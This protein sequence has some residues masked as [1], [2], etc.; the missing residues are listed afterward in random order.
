MPLDIIKGKN[1]VHYDELEEVKVPTRWGDVD[2]VLYHEGGPFTGTAWSTIND[3]HTECTTY[4]GMRHGAYITADT[5]GRVLFEGYYQF[6]QMVGIHN[7]YYLSGAISSVTV[8]GVEENKVS[9]RQYN[10][11]GVLVREVKDRPWSISQ[12]NDDG[13]LFF[14]TNHSGLR[15]FNRTGFCV[16]FQDKVIRNVAVPDDNELYLCACELLDDI[17]NGFNQCNVV[18]DWL[19]SELECDV[20]RAQELHLLLLNHSNLE[21]VKQILHFRVQKYVVADLIRLMSQNIRATVSGFQRRNGLGPLTLSEYASQ[22]LDR[23]ANEIEGEGKAEIVSAVKKFEERLAKIDCRR[24]IHNKKKQA[25]KKKW[26][27]IE[28][29]LKKSDAYYFSVKSLKPAK[30]GD[31]PQSLVNKLFAKPSQS[32]ENMFYCHYYD[33]VVG[34]NTYRTKFQDE[35]KEVPLTKIVRYRLKNPIESYVVE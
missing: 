25:V 33:F 5:H 19:K 27:E 31:P 24:A 1:R 26:P 17:Q 12:W 3:L 23:Y 20:T 15:L 14:E 21:V 22:R 8:F 6:N 11:N 30:K 16:L 28:A 32:A 29:V 2:T 13:H 10:C 7:E 35:S 9:T 18:F 34:G 4:L